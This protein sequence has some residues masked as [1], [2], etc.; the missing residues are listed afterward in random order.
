MKW[1]D[2]IKMDVWETGRED[3]GWTAWP[4]TVSSGGIVSHVIV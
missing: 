3:G 4:G 2:N 1:L